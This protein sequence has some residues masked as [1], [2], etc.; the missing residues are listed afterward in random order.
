[1]PLISLGE[2]LPD[3]PAYQNRGVL[4]ATDVY[5]AAHGYVPAKQL[6]LST[7][8]LDARPRGAIRARDTGGTAYE[9]AGDETKLYQNVSN[10]WTDR[11]KVGGYS[12][13]ASERWEFVAWKNKTL[14]VNFSDDPQQITFG[15][16]IFSDLT[17]ALRARHITRIRDFVVMANTFD[18]TDGN[19]PSRVRWSA[20]NDETDW[21]VSA[22]TLSDFQDLQT[23]SVERIF[24]GEFGVIFQPQSVWRMT[25]VGA[26]I[27]FQFD[28]VAPGI[29]LIAPGAAA[30]DGDI[31]YFLSNKGFMQLAHG[32]QPTPIG[33][34]KVDRFISEDL[35]Q[36]NLERISA[37]TDPASHRVYW[38][39]PGAGNT[40]GRPNK[41]I[42]YDPALQRWSL[43]NEDVELIWGAGGVSTTLEGLDSIS[44]SLDDL[45][46]SLDS[47][48]WAGA[49]SEIGVFDEDFKSGFFDGDN[50]TGV[51]ETAE[52][53]FN[54][55][56]RTRLKGFRGIVD[57]GTVTAELGTRNSQADM[58]SYSSTLTAR[59]EGRFTPRSND[60]Y[61]RFRL[62]CS[63]A[64]KTASGVQIDREDI[65]GGGRR[66]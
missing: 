66:G 17:T 1:M 40:G 31:I 38:A 35:D 5:P 10:A 59:T 7:D 13:A 23:A 60:R 54:E 42:V 16:S 58:V 18:G 27:V 20:F 12:T 63:N 8:A 44:A 22:S 50:R 19:V 28:E 56:G 36:N 4:T 64:W 3:R 47:A 30:Q 52:V 53:E 65:R 2:W 9:Y 25:F 41:V 24:G 45:E 37:I 51:I 32:A 11:S 48:R 21:T 34:G 33:V 26:P 15:A 6:S 39:Y 29:G 49:G 43:L 62:N 46:V 57:G 14:A 55:G 61:H